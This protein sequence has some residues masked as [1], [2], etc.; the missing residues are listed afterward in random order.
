MSAWINE[1]MNGKQINK[2]LLI[3]DI[4]IYLKESNI[5]KV[6]DEINGNLAKPEIA[7]LIMTLLEDLIVSCR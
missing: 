2:S 6:K 7:L 4:F 5:K 3:I 1:Y